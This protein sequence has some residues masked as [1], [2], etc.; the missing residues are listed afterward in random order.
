MSAYLSAVNRKRLYAGLL[1][2]QTDPDARGHLQQALLQGAVLHL[3]CALGF[4]LMEIAETYQCADP[5]SIVEIEGLAAALE[6]VDKTPAESRELQHLAATPGSWLY[7]LKDC[8]GA[9]L[10]VRNAP[11]GPQEQDGDLI[12]AVAIA[13]REDW[14][15]LEYSD[16][17]EWLRAF[18]EM[19]DRQREVMVEC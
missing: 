12:P 14:S 4:Y 9:L 1:L 6:A 3:H 18:N 16:V 2:E 11:A 17:G 15:L 13:D 10:R 5:D 7:R 8:H 19:V